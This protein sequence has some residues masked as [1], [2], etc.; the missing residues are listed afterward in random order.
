MLVVVV[1]WVAIAW[2]VLI[3]VSAFAGAASGAGLGQVG[4]ALLFVAYGATLIKRDRRAMAF[5]WV[6]VA[7]FGLAVIL[8]GLV[9]LQIIVWVALLAFALYLRKHPGVLRTS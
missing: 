1:G 9:P 6:I 4:A 8:G 2:A 7:L 3:V 5:T